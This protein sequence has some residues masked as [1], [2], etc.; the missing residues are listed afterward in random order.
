MSKWKYDY[1]SKTGLYHIKENLI[2]QDKIKV[3]ENDECIVA[4]LS[5]GLG[6]L[7]KSDL[8]AETAV[9]TICDCF[10]D[11]AS[12]NFA[13]YVNDSKHEALRMIAD[14]IIKCT[15]DSI[16]NNLE[17][18]RIDRRNADCT[19]AFVFISKRFENALI[20]CIG[21][22][23]VCIIKKSD[24]VVYSQHNLSANGTATLGMTEAS[25][26]LKLSFLDLKD[27][28]ILGFI[29]TSDGLENEIYMKG[30]NHVLKSA[31]E[32][33]NSL[34]SDNFKPFI[35]D[36]V[37]NLTQTE[38][39]YFDDDIS[40]VVI[41]RSEN[42]ITLEDD[43]TWLC[44]CGARNSMIE[45]YCH[46]CDRDFTI[47]YENAPDFKKYGG[48]TEF[49]K[50]INKNPNEERKLIGLKSEP[51]CEYKKAD[52]EYNF[53]NSHCV[54]CHVESYESDYDDLPYKTSHYG[55]E[56]SNGYD[57]NQQPQRNEAKYSQQIS[58]PPKNTKKNGKKKVPKNTKSQRARV[59]H[60]F[61]A[62]TGAVIL[63]TGIVIGSF[64]TVLS[65][66]ESIKTLSDEVDSLNQKYTELQTTLTTLSN[67]PTEKSLS[68]SNKLQDG[69]IYWGEMSNGEP[70]G[71]GL[72]L[73]DGRY[74]IG[75]FLNG[76]MT[77]EIT[78]ISE[79]GSYIGAEFYPEQYE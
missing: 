1:Y 60:I 15:N 26:F 5:D 47:L 69:S 67:L 24:T 41:S 78:V 75:K 59:R 57:E 42:P 76:S 61:L 56:S 12:E 23:A 19:L 49:F 6:S 74:Y 48:K 46:K 62:A 36:K 16:N 63:I 68:G 20:G 45:T 39:T 58:R 18:A 31:E 44:T 3:F 53:N 64:F 14:A 28:D 55:E 37:N 9:N 4:A 7:S 51:D 50:L 52:S 11:K 33:F 40:I 35:E 70:N 34:Q 72:L 17:N 21:D 29:L 79:D 71:N 22:S 25:D 43:P 73:K 54:D 77:G 27:N 8:A 38:D 66:S 13:D 2:C 65:M 30:S 10:K 32:Y